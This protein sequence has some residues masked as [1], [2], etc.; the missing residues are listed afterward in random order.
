MESPD[1]SWLPEAPDLPWPPKLPASVLETICAL[2]A[3]CV[4]VSSRS[5]SLP[6]VSSAPPWRAPVSSAPP[7]W[8]PVSSAPPRWAP[9]LSAPHGPGP[10]S[11]PL[12]PPP[13]HRPP[14]FFYVWSVWK[15]LFGGLCH[16]SGS[17]AHAHSPH[18]L[19]HTTAAH[20]PRTAFPIHHC[21]NHTAVT[22]HSFALITQLR[23]VRHAYKPW[24]CLAPSDISERLPQVCFPVYYL[25]CFY[26][27]DRLLPAFWYPLCLL[28]APTIALPLFINLPCLR[29]TC[30]CYRTLPVWSPL[31]FI[32]IK[33]HLDLNSTDPSHYR[34]NENIR[35]DD[36]ENIW[37]DQQER[38]GVHQETFISWMLFCICGNMKCTVIGQARVHFT[39]NTFVQK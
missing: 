8:A 5:Q 19:H 1:P 31:V 6:W 11:P 17:W 29:Y 25:D 16:E 38:Q 10:P 13:L 22:N 21:T 24:T 30:Y 18:L 37:P 23:S 9:D 4:S 28:P 7:W 14:G 15:P 39:C 34:G 32:L 20:H 26:D 35:C 33:L 36:L 27:S 3:S 12:I 2:S